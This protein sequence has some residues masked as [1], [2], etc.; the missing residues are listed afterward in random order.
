MRHD[1]AAIN[2]G[3]PL[4]RGPMWPLAKSGNPKAKRMERDPV[5]TDHNNP[6]SRGPSGLLRSSKSG[7]NRPTSVETT[8][9]ASMDF[10]KA[11]PMRR[12]PAFGEEENPLSRGPM[13]PV[14]KSGKQAHKSADGNLLAI[15]TPNAKRTTVAGNLPLTTIAAP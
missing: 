12:D 10:E 6:L 2:N 14:A 1:L 13:W 5:A 3:N 9:N 11:K 15:A 8:D 7:K 4:S